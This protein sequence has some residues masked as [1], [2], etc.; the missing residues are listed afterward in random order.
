MEN[1]GSRRSVSSNDDA[2]ADDD[3][4]SNIVDAFFFLLLLPH[5]TGPV[6]RSSAPGKLRQGQGEV[7]AGSTEEREEAERGAEGEKRG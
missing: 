3:T 7:L 5:T 6:P 1:S 4:G 2:D